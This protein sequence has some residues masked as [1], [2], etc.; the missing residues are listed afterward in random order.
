[1]AAIE[2]SAP[3][4]ATA[5][6]WLLSTIVATWALARR[7][8]NWD[9][10]ESHET[11]LYGHKGEPGLIQ[12]FKTLEE[13]RVQAIEDALEALAERVKLLINAL[14]AHGSGAH[15]IGENVRKKMREQAQEAY[16]EIESQRRRLLA[17]QSSRFEVRPKSSF[18]VVEE[19]EDPFPHRRLLEEPPGDRRKK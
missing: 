9:D 3:L 18:V 8:K 2:L 11:A 16:R 14:D 5:V 12:R 19:E 15:Q 4:A 17:D 13:H 10:A 6:G 7:S 1:V